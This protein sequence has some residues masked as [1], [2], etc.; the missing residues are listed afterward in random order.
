MSDCKPWKNPLAGQLRSEDGPQLRKTFQSL[1]R[2]SHQFGDCAGGGAS[3]L[4]GGEIVQCESVRIVGSSAWGQATY[5]SVTWTAGG[6]EPHYDQ[7]DLVGL[8]L[9]EDG[10]YAISCSVSVVPDYVYSSNKTYG[11]YFGY[12]AIPLDGSTWNTTWSVGGSTRVGDYLYNA[13][14]TG[15][16]NVAVAATAGTIVVVRY[17][18]SGS[19]INQPLATTHMDG[20]IQV[21]K[22][23]DFNLEDYDPPCQQTPM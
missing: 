23:A 9:P 16:A 7:G 14:T 1:E 18:Q 15:G 21:R 20:S 17:T 3:P 12:Y 6:V 4:V 8:V 2:W 10:I 11:Y 19:P 22:V 5:E 13:V